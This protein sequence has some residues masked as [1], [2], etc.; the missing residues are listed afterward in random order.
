M[1]PKDR[2]MICR[3]AGN[4]AGNLEA[5]ERATWPRDD[6]VAG[7]SVDIA[8]AILEDV[9]KRIAESSRAK[10]RAHSADVHDRIDRVI[11]RLN[12]VGFLAGALTDYAQTLQ[13]LEP[14]ASPGEVGVLNVARTAV[15]RLADIE[16][17]R[18]KV[19]GSASS[20]PKNEDPDRDR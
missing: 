16:I 9:D 7:E 10:I 17:E 11:E 4:I 14:Y 18:A 20:A 5:H 1:N 3:I 6:D 15:L 13:D 19:Q 8:I 2:S 12:S